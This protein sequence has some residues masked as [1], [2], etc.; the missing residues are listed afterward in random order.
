MALHLW[1]KEKALRR[2]VESDVIVSKQTLWDIAERAPTTLDELRS[3]DGLGPWRLAN[4]GQEILQI[5]AQHML[6]H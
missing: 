5:L 4:Y 2:G 1:R 3:V 6:D